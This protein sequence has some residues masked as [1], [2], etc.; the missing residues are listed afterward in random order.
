MYLVTYLTNQTNLIIL[1]FNYFLQFDRFSISSPFPHVGTMPLLFPWMF[2]P[3][4]K[5]LLPSLVSL[6][7]NLISLR[8]N[9]PFPREILPAWV[10][11]I[12]TV[13]PMSRS[14]I[15]TSLPIPIIP[16]GADLDWMCLGWRRLYIQ[17]VVG[18]KYCGKVQGYLYT[19]WQGA[20][21]IDYGIVSGKIGIGLGLLTYINIICIFLIYPLDNFPCINPVTYLMNTNKRTQIMKKENHLR[22]D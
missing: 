5:N 3:C 16:L 18:W 1:V 20:S 12:K 6:P 19:F 14:R 7:W 2:N 15:D 10:P 11:L 17:H 21:V 13:I 9:A 8:L 22:R 4:L